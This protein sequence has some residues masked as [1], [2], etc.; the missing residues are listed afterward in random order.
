VT[1]IDELA[2]QVSE[3][4]QLVSS[5]QRTLNP[6]DASG[7]PVPTSFE[8]GTGARDMD[9]PRWQIGKSWTVLA[10]DEPESHDSVY[11][12]S[13]YGQSTGDIES[14]SLAEAIQV[15]GALLAAARYVTAGAGRSLSLASGGD[16]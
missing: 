7:L 2:A 4:S 6:V 14:M 12:R 13:H 3:L 10:L 5:L 15:A 9:G 11:I 16:A 8:K 1:T